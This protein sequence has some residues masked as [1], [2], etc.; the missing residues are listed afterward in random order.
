M[1]SNTFSLERSK[2]QPLTKRNLR[3]LNIAQTWESILTHPA[4]V[5]EDDYGVKHNPIGFSLNKSSFGD[6]PGTAFALG[7][8]AYLNLGEPLIEERGGISQ[9]PPDSF[10]SRTYVNRGS[11]PM[12]FTDSVDFTVSNQVNWSLG[13]TTQL[14]FGGSIGAQLQLQLQAQLQLQLQAQLQAGVST[15]LQNSVNQKNATTVTNKNSK[16]SV[17]TDQSNA[18]EAGTT[19]GMTNS[20]NASATNSVTGS[21]SF[22]TQAAPPAR[23]T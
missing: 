3:E 14:T 15:G 8:L 21:S 10:S 20:A 9:P 18:T 4:L 13:G 2:R 22:S 16:D 7:W 23:R 19:N 11:T 17:G 6:F 5:Y 1:P 12:T